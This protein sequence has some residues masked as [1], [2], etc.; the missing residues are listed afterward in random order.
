MEV[1]DQEESH[2]NTIFTW[3]SFVGEPYRIRKFENKTRGIGAQENTH[4]V[5]KYRTG[6][7]KNST[8]N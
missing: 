1:C 2:K 3:M 6:C 4:T 5:G 7:I 8:L